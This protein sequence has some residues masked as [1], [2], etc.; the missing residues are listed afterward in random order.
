MRMRRNG[1]GGP[2]ENNEE[3]EIARRP[4]SRLGQM[5]AGLNEFSRSSAYNRSRSPLNRRSSDESERYN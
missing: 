2:E 1:E 5:F 3:D 4:R